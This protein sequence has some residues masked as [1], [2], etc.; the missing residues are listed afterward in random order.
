MS[1]APHQP[2]PSRASARI[3]LTHAQRVLG[4]NPPM[5]AGERS[6]M[7]A[8]LRVV[9]EHLDPKRIIEDDVE[10][11]KSHARRMQPRWNSIPDELWAEVEALAAKV[12]PLVA[13]WGGDDATPEWVERQQEKMAEV[14][15]DALVDAASRG[16]YTP[17]EEE[18]AAGEAAAERAQQG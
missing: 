3:N 18:C 9:G 7:I 5:T 6:S 15:G 8:A 10:A 1:A 11:A 4:G 14:L 16:V 12:L 17:S 13:Q 2:R